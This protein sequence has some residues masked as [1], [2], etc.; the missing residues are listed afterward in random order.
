[1][2][3]P[4]SNFFSVVE[5]GRAIIAGCEKCPICVNSVQ[6][7]ALQ[8]A[9]RL[10]TAS[11]MTKTAQPSLLLTSSRDATRRKR[12]GSGNETDNSL[13]FEPPAPDGD[14]GLTAWG[15][16]PGHPHYDLHRATG[17]VRSSS[18][19]AG[20]LLSASRSTTCSSPTRHRK[21]K[22]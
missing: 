9:T 6:R 18:C 13:S 19:D 11:G 5:N 8:L 7:K 1:M 21:R 12:S 22:K 3:T 2:A 17:D 16:M 10:R 15:Y 4:F 14:D 20:M